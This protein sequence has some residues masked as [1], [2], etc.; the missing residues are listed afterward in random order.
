MFKKTIAAA[1]L[2]ALS[3]GA[4]AADYFVVV[5][6]PGRPKSTATAEISAAL[7]AYSVPSGVAGTVYAGFDFKPL[8]QVTGDPAYSAADARW[9]VTSGA[10]PAGLSLNTTTGLLSGTPT[11]ASDSYVGVQATYKT[12]TAQQT[13]RLLVDAATYTGSLSADTNADFGAVQVGSSAVRSFTFRNTGNS[14]LTGLYPSVTGAGLT[15]DAGSTCGTQAAPATLPLAATCSVQVRY[16]PADESAPLTSAKLSMGSYANVALTGSGTL[17]ADPYYSNVTFLMHAETSLA[18][19]SA[20]GVGLAV[21]GSV[22]V[23]SPAMYGT[24]GALF[25]SASYLTATSGTAGFDMSAASAW[26]VEG[27]FKADST[28][29][30]GGYNHRLVSIAKDGSGWEAIA[31]A[32]NGTSVR[33]MLGSAVSPAFNIGTINGTYTSNTWTHYA[34]VFTGSQYQ[35]YVNGTLAG[36]LTSSTKVYGSIGAV[37][38]G[39][40]NALAAT[41]MYRGSMDEI[42]VTKGV[43]RY[44]SNF[45]VPT[46]AFANH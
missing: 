31:L 12:K 39:T 27:W 14:P 22:S 36:S 26:T 15:V 9:V 28:L 21:T 11:A 5:P 44:T 8:L 23:S 33:A 17:P 32:V 42:R 41:S 6:L 16:T 30:G 19:T 35:L 45:S 18:D 40:D 20:A 29:N 34:L 43:A 4:L 13:Y 2:A 7:N 46:Q 3:A 37:R 25:G 38:F 1:A 24:G 10:L